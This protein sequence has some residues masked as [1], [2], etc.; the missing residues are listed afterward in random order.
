MLPL[1]YRVLSG[2]QILHMSCRWTIK[3]RA[4]NWNRIGEP[5]WG[6][7]DKA[8]YAL[9]TDIKNRACTFRGC[10]DNAGEVIDR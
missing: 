7:S 10:R 2:E 1:T 3:Q 9:L 6:R 8:A 5:H 4:P